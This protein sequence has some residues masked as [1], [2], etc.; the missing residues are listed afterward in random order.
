M[1]SFKLKFR[2]S[3]ILSKEGTLYFQVIHKRTARQINTGFKLFAAEW[4]DYHG[5]IILS[6]EDTNRKN[7]LNSIWNKIQLDKLRLRTIIATFN[8]S[9][10]EYSTDQIIYSFFSSTTEHSLSVFMNHVIERLKSLGKFRTAET[11]SVTLRSF[12]RYRRGYDINLDFITVDL[13]QAYEAYLKETNVNMNTVSFYM[14][15]LRAVYNRAVEAEIISQKWPF[16]SVYTGINKTIKRAI[17]LEELRSIKDADL[18]WNHTLSFA[19]DMFLF[20]FYTRGMAFIDIAFLKKSYLKD[21]ALSYRRK[22]T[23]QQL[24][25]R[26]EIYMQEIIDRYSLTDSQYMLPIISN[27]GENERKQYLNASRQINRKLGALGRILVLHIPLT[28]YVARHSWASIARDK[29]IPLSVISEG[30][31]HDSL[32]TTEIYLSSIKTDVV[33]KANLDIISDLQ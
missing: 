24:F 29:N 11:Y 5:D 15:N 19:R 6:T 30:M 22:K 17:S 26:W 27:Q 13:L 33:D 3:S 21:G 28:F 10:I 31:G 16:K 14:R 1:T 4:D 20:S 12:M 25:I 18:S 32:S 23:G 9:G 7:Y 2:H 8:Q